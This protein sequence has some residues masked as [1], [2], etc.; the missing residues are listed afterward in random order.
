MEDKRS[1]EKK[2]A[3]AVDARQYQTRTHQFKWMNKKL[4]I[5]I[6]L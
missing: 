4:N 6:E 2:R 1:R 5:F 3:R